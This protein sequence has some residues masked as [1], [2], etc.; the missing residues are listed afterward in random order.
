M[1]SLP[2]QSVAAYPAAESTHAIRAEGGPLARDIESRPA[3]TDA[4]SPNVERMGSR[5]PAREVTKNI[6]SVPPRVAATTEMRRT[7]NTVHA[8]DVELARNNESNS[9][10]TDTTQPAVETE[11]GTELTQSH[12]L[13][14][15]TVLR[16]PHLANELRAIEKQ[17][18][19]FRQIQ[20]PSPATQGLAEQKSEAATSS[21]ELESAR[22]Q[23]EILRQ[24]IRELEEQSDW[25]PPPLYN[26]PV[27]APP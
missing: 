27:E 2:T 22:Q 14:P 18:E 24:R 25:V 19:A 11:I 21:E 15:Q 3:R 5:N 26:D 10:R 20:Q 6:E 12:A 23:N 9:V 1:E 7:D 8:G 13:Q 16:L 4:T 17:H